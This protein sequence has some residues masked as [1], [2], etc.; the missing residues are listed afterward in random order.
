MILCLRNLITELHRISVQSGTQNLSQ[1]LNWR[2]EMSEQISCLPLY[3]RVHVLLHNESRNAWQIQYTFT[4]SDKF[5][6][7]TAFRLSS[8]LRALWLL[9]L[10][11]SI[12]LLTGFLLLSD[13]A[14]GRPIDSFP[15]LCSLLSLWWSLSVR[16]SVVEL[17]CEPLCKECCKHASTFN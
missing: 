10:M 16:T 1:F 9:C 4:R 11:R 2:Y 7:L 8:E 13:P 6:L 3:H 12:T 17:P 14:R 15:S 5:K